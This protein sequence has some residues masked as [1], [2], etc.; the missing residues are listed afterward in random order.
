MDE[1]G[2]KFVLNP[3]G[4]LFHPQIDK[5]NHYKTL[6]FNSETGKYLKVNR[7]G[8]SILKM[9]DDNLGISLPKVAKLL[10]QEVTK[11]E[12]FVNLMI[13]ENVVLEE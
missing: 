8:Y 9:I 4:V 5:L 6:V 11:I 13:Q 7:F 1:Q 10:N 3:Y 2:H 12:K